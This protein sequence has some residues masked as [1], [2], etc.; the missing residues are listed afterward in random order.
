MVLVVSLSFFS[1]SG[2]GGLFKSFFRIGS[3]IY[4]GGQV[5]LPMLLDDVVAPGWLTKKQFYQ[6]FALVQARG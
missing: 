4:G 3:I 2:L 5:V 6:G 1:D